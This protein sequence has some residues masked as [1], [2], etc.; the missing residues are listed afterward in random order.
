MQFKT[1]YKLAKKNMARQTFVTYLQK[2]TDRHVITRRVA[3]RTVY[4]SYNLKAPEQEV[5]SKWIGF[6]RERLS[7]IPDDIR[8]L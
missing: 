1:L 8:L 7:Y 3:G 2:A 4:Y 6:A 5:L